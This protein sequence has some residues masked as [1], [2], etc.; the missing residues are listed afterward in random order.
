MERP[1]AQQR[2]DERR[3]LWD[4]RSPV[5]RRAGKE[6]RVEERRR[7]D[8]KGASEHRLRSDRRGPDR[9]SAP[10][11]RD[12]AARRREQ[13]RRATPTPYT[14][15]QLA[16]LRKR[17]ASPGPVSC[18]ACGGRVVLDPA[19]RGGAGIARGVLCY[20]CGRAAVVPRAWAAR[21]LIA[22]QDAALR[23]TLRG[24]LVGGGHDVVETDD[25]SVALAAYRAAPADVIF[26]DV[27]APGRVPAPEFQRQLESSF[28]GA[29]I[30]AVVGRKSYAGVDPLMVV[31]GL[32][33]VR[34]IRLPISG[35]E[36]LRRVEDARA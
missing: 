36:L 10:E 2:Q 17:F 24:V 14:A 28:P 7:S 25:T 6:R 4:R 9:R 35:E 3:R 29:R 34:S 5:P 15:T 8:R 12:A 11:R 27:L 26:L 19:Q 18:P 20:G 16:E 33:G 22:I 31:P 21:V 23:K 30:I 32:K 13:R 1:S